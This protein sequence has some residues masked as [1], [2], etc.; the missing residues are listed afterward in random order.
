M[1]DWTQDPD[2]EFILGSLVSYAIKNSVSKKPLQL[3]AVLASFSY[4]NHAFC[5]LIR[6]N[7]YI[8][9]FLNIY[10]IVT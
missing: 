5:T 8:W 3:M 9:R 2:Y 4:Y 1:L 6:M 10:F 7:V